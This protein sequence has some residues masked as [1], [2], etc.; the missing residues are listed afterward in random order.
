MREVIASRTFV[1]GFNVWFCL[2]VAVCSA[3]AVACMCVYSLHVLYICCTCLPYV[4][5][6]STKGDRTIDRV[7]VNGLKHVWY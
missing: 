6:K 3:V 5:G 2:F 7:R 4:W 1:L